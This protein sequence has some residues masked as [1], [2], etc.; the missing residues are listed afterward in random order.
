MRHGASPDAP[1]GP[2]EPAALIL[3]PLRG[4]ERVIGVLYLKR[5]GSDARFD[6]REFEIVRLFAAHVSIALQ[7]A[8]THRAVELRAQTDALTEL[9]NHGTFREDLRLAVDR[10]QP[11]SLLMLDLDDFKAYNDRHGHEAGNQLLK[12]I[13]VAVDAACRER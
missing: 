2:A 13:A 12:G 7:N 6:E 8:L 10:A 11:F 9:R 1:G 3:A 5:L 4:Q